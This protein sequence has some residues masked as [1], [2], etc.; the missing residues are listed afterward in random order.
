MRAPGSAPTHLGPHCADRGP[1]A[2][3]RRTDAQV[4]RRVG[5]GLTPMPT[6]PRPRGRPPRRRRAQVTLWVEPGTAARL[7]TLAAERG[8]TLSAAGSALLEEALRA[9]VD[10]EHAALLVPAVEQVIVAQH[11]R[12]YELLVRVCL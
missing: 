9:A 2:R 6:S 5:E 10:H 1:H 7:R 4:A 3:A 11:H 12:L 8:L